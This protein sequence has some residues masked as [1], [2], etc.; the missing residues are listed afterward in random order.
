[1][2]AMV[3]VMEVSSHSYLTNPRPRSDFSGGCRV[4]HPTNLEQF[5]FNCPGPC[6]NMGAIDNSVTATWQRGQTVEV[7]WSKNN[8]RGGFVR[9]TIVRKEDMMNRQSHADLA[10]AYS[11]WD[12]QQVGCQNDF[13]CGTDQQKVAFKEFIRVPPIYPDGEYI[14]GWAWFGGDGDLADY[15]S[16][17]NIR[18]QGG[19]L[20][21][22]YTPVT[23]R[24]DSKTDTVGDCA[25]EPCYRGGLV[26][27]LPKK[28]AGGNPPAISFGAGGNPP[29][30]PP[31]NNGGGGGGGAGLENGGVYLLHTQHAYDSCVDAGGD[32]DGS[33][34]QIWGCY[35]GANQRWKL[36]DRGSGWSLTEQKGFKAL[37]IYQ[38]YDNGAMTQTWGWSGA[39]NQL[40]YPERQGDGSYAFKSKFSGKY[41]DVAGM[42]RDNG[43]RIQQW[44]FSGAGNQKFVLQRV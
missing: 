10:F 37:D 3:A 32:G 42:S 20:E 18:I 27:R 5:T 17:A 23:A 4:G 6:E 12:S 24:C 9:W 2:V 28:F 21:N 38:T 31:P 8:H 26:N 14:L 36:E 22:A 43:A 40:W 44:D 19:P 29:P 41:L 11:C 34:V 7:R 16:C 1:M 33:P 13:E 15:H 30:P 25:V 39:A 35:G